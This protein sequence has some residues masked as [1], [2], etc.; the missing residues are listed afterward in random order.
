MSSCSTDERDDS[1]DIQPGIGSLTPKK[2][3]LMLKAADDADLPI[4]GRRF[5]ITGFL[6]NYYGVDVHAG[7]DGHSVRLICKQNETVFNGEDF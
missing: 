6:G 3:R 5:V 4:Q 7:R 2:A 1:L